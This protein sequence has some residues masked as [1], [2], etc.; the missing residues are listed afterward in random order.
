M[1]KSGTITKYSYY[2]IIIHFVFR[3]AEALKVTVAGES[4]SILILALVNLVNKVIQM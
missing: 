3:Q 1:Y 4:E 2:I